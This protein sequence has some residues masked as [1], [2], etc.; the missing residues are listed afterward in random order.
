[1]EAI[2]YLE[3]ALALGVEETADIHEH[4][5]DL[6]VVLGEYNRALND[7]EVAAAHVTVA[8]SARLE[9]KSVI[10]TIGWATCRSHP[11][12]SK[13]HWPKIIELSWRCRFL[14]ESSLVAAQSGDQDDAAGIGANI[15]GSGR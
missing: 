12:I 13:P 6:R 5:G 4:L 10:S 7:F 9:G 11:D 2:G 3:H 8:E 15:T 14:A 1:M